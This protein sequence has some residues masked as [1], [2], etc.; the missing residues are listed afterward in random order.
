MKI[1]LLYKIVGL[2]MLCSAKK[3]LFNTTTA[4]TSKFSFV[5]FFIFLILRFYSLFLSLK[6]VFPMLT[7]TEKK[8][9]NLLTSPP[10]NTYPKINHFKFSFNFR[11]T[12]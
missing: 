9:Q 1:V 8:E 3:E 12:F 4:Q 11:F 5:F 6:Y 2:N 10:A 7:Y